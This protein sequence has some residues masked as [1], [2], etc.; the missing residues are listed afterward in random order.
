MDTS[1][2]K[3]DFV[4]VN[5]IKLHYLDWGGRGEALIFLTGAGSSAHVFDRIAP[6]FT[7]KF[8]VLALTRRGQGESDYPESGYDLDTLIDDIL[9]FMGAL[10]IDKA[11][12]AGHSFAGVELTYLTEKHPERVAKLIYLDAVYDPKGMKEVLKNSPVNEI[13]PPEEKTEFSTVEEYIE[14]LKHL[15]PDLAQ[16]W[17]EIFVTTIMFDLEKNSNGKFVEK[18]TSA[19]T[20]QMIESATMYDP[21]YANIKAPVLRFEAQGNP[22]RPSYFTEEQKK[23]AD[24]FHR[25]QWKPF[26]RQV[27]ARFK[28]NIPQAKVIEIPDGHH[29]CFIA[30]E[31]LVY[32]EMRKFLTG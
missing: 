12:F 25:N 15:R 29:Y 19:I 1:P 3:S 24:D 2:H 32:D 23:A 21:Q 5:G 17:D 16:L 11:A 22:I 13:Q 9:D 20:R 8:R 28:K 10:K 26:A 6:R 31:N 30:Q 4:R 18:D 7:D 27:T 14:Y